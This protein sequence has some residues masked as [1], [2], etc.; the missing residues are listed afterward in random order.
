MIKKILGGYGR[1]IDTSNYTALAHAIR[2]ARAIK[3]DFEKNKQLISDAVKPAAPADSATTI[4]AQ[5]VRC[6]KIRR[7]ELVEPPQFSDDE[8][9]RRA[10]M[11]VNLG[12]RRR[13]EEE[14]K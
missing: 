11:I 6:G 9:G 10:K 8:H 3:N 1:T 13:G 14:L 5:I 12:R 2:E 7:A 4:A